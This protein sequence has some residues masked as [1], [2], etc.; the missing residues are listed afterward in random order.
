M[1]KHGNYG[2]SAISGSSNVIESLGYKFKNDNAALKRE[3]D[4]ANICFMHAP[5]FHPALKM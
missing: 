2:A 1:T 4:E 5:L 3:L